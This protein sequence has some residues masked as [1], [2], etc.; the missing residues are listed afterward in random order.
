MKV[1][2]KIKKS[3]DNIKFLGI[4]YNPNN[5]KQ[6]VYLFYL[7]ENDFNSCQYDDWFQ[8]IENGIYQC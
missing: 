5:L 8:N 1:L 2:A 4:E 3:N 6:G 7:L